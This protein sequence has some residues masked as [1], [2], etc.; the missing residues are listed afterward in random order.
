MAR[1]MTETQA[2]ILLAQFGIEV[3]EG[4][5][6][7]G[8][9][10]A[11]EA[12][13]RLGFPVA[14][15]VSHNE[16][17]HKTD[18][19]GVALNI[20]SDEDLKWEAARIL[21]LADGAAL[22]VEKMAED[23]G[24]DLICGLKRDPV[25]GAVVMVG[26][27]GIYAEILKDTSLHV[28]KLDETQAM[29]MIDRLKSRPLLDGARGKAPLDRKALA[30]ALIKISRMAE[31]RPDLMELDI[32]P[33]RL[34]ENGAL[35]LDAFAVV[36]DK[37]ETKSSD[38][39]AYSNERVDKFFNPKS[40]AV[41]G[42]ST[43]GARAGNI[44]IRNM[45]TLGYKGGI[46]PVNPAGGVI[47]E[48][49]AYPTIKDCPQTPDAAVLA[50]PF[51]QVEKVMAQ[52]AEAGVKHAIVVSGGFSD[53][54][55]DGKLR[56][57]R[58]LE[59]CANH[60]IHLM[61]PNSIGAV[62]AHSGF[63]TSIGIL[64][65]MKPTGV[66]IFGQSGTFSTGFAL[67]EITRRNRGFA[68]IACMGNKAD[69]DESDFLEYLADDEKTRVIGCYVESVKDGERFMRAAKNACKKK[70]VVILKSGRTEVGAKAAASHTGALAGSDRVYDAVFRQSG[71]IRVD[72]FEEFFGT[73]RAFDMCPA[74]KGNR[75][76]V[77]SITGVGCVLAADACGMRGMQIA[78]LTDGTKENLEELV[79]D[80]AVITNP[81][82]IWST[83]EQ[84]GGADAFRKMS[85]H[86]IADENV[87]ILLVIH[88]L[89][90]EGAFDA[91]KAFAPIRQAHPDKPIMACYLGGRKDLLE[92]YQTGLESIGV[93]VFK[94]PLSAVSAASRL[95]QRS[96]S[97]KSS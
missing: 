58:V 6:C 86:I 34:Y 82:D 53:A 76:G 60:G 75:I 42:P 64:P 51:H 29:A 15:K 88:V 28:G 95:Y 92:N 1:P 24:L 9:E 85:E 71:M 32:N 90:E 61:G 83:I 67:E 33:L 45:K 68:K 27:G 65:P 22:R 72:D 17:A 13:H 66:S 31:K 54:G 94:G 43:S 80:W 26:T 73:L 52:A 50:L 16:L 20:E 56:E 74:P 55:A 49:P 78:A 37:P 5:E 70:P 2:K 38:S 59:I 10:E 41:I 11:A 36:G 91:A 57:K 8:V 47:E 44:I 63:C 14:L 19:G 3:V 39:A 35:A 79:P 93:P 87:D 62:D 7:T 84:R 25:F 48:L 30:Q 21:A 18:V 40:V 46:Y 69:V 12:A 96:L 97:N 23:G 4:L 89:L 77:V 81:A